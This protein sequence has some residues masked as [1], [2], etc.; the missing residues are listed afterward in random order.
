MSWQRLAQ[1]WIP[2]TAL[3]ASTTVLDILLASSLRTQSLELLSLHRY[4]QTSQSGSDTRSELGRMLEVLRPD[5]RQ[6]SWSLYVENLKL[7]LLQNSSLPHLLAQ[8][9]SEDT[10]RTSLTTV[11]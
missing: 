9:E 1:A 11:L 10:V 3:V 2:D 7:K 5:S 6:L 8:R 4:C